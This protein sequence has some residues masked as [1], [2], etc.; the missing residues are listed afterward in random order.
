VGIYI[1]ALWGQT[2]SMIEP[3]YPD[4]RGFLFTHMPG[5]LWRF[6]YSSRRAGRSDASSARAG[7]QP[8]PSFAWHLIGPFACALSLRLP[9]Y[10]RAQMWM[11]DAVFRPRPGQPRYPGAR[12]DS[13]AAIG[14]LKYISDWVNN[15][16]ICITAWTRSPPSSHPQP[17]TH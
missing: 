5:L 11:R 4:L 10:L 15:C 14:E 2:G 8:S 17:P 12:L 1:F 3:A 13:L 7:P 6:P 9:D 16:A